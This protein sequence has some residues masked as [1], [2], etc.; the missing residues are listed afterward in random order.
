MENDK[1]K[2]RQDWQVVFAWMP[3]RLIDGSIVWL[4]IV[5]RRPKNGCNIKNR[6]FEYDHAIVGGQ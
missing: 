3:K 4:D 2:Q 1:S 5:K 6:Q